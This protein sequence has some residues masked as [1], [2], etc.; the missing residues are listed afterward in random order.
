MT[1]PTDHTQA[2]LRRTDAQLDRLQAD[3]TDLRGR[4]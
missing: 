2:L 1:E 4:L 3:V